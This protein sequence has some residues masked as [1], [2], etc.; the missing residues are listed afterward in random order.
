MNTNYKVAATYRRIKNDI[1]GNPRYVVNFLSISG[2]NAW[3]HLTD[4][5]EISGKFSE[6]E[7]GFIVRSYNIDTTIKSMTFHPIHSIVCL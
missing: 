2:S 6:K 5:T 1:N 3:Y 7:R 4:S